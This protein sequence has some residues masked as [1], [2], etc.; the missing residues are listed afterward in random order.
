MNKRVEKFLEKV[1]TPEYQKTYLENTAPKIAKVLGT[2][3]K[4]RNK[5]HD[6]KNLGDT[7]C[8]VC[9]IKGCD[10]ENGPDFLTKD[11]EKVTT[12]K[13]GN[14]IEDFADKLMLNML[15]NYHKKVWEKKNF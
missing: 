9:A 13:V 10:N 3:G 15:K 1:N 5:R 8:P 6:P 7:I 12:S 11:I 4:R 14:T 2:T